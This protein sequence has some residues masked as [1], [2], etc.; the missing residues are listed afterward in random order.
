MNAAPTPPTLPARL[1]FIRS[2]AAEMQRYRGPH[3]AEAVLLVKLCR[4]WC[5]IVRQADGPDAGSPRGWPGRC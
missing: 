4:L 1:E 5:S 3:H 2:L